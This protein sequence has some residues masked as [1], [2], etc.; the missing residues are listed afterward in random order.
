MTDYVQKPIITSET[1]FFAKEGTFFQLTCSVEVKPGHLYRADFILPNGAIARTNDFM[2]VSD[3]AHDGTNMHIAHINLSVSNAIQSR[4]Q[5]EYKCIVTDYHN[6][7]NSNYATLTFVS[8][9]NVEIKDIS[10]SVVNITRVRKQAQFVID[11]IAY[12]AATLYWY[13][14]RNELISTDNMAIRK[15]YE[16][17]ITDKSDFM[18]VKFKIKHPE[19]EDFGNYTLVFATVSRNFTATVR[20]VVSGKS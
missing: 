13:N 10:S 14:N 7:T 8:D 12:P 9:T 5:G 17:E 1:K 3:L 6:N 20:L 4:D 15:K 2:T 11:Y 16:V 19:L 18:S